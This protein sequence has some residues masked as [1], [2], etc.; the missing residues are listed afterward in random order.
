MRSATEVAALAADPDGDL[1]RDI[2]PVAGRRGFE[3]LL[4]PVAEA[5]ARGARDPQRER[6]RAVTPRAALGPRLG[7]ARVR[8]EACLV[9]PRIE[10]RLR[11]PARRARPPRERQAHLLGRALGDA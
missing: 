4:E 9:E 1:L 11:I 7:D 10:V 6:V 3:V 5:L 2:E 8:I